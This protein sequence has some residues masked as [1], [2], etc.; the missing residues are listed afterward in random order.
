ML[1]NKKNSALNSITS[2]F[3]T[4]YSVGC[5]FIEVYQ[6]K[7]LFHVAAIPI[8]A[9]FTGNKVKITDKAIELFL[10]G[11]NIFKKSIIKFDKP[12]AEHSYTII[13]DDKNRAYGIGELLYS[14]NKVDTLPENT[15]VIKN[16]IDVG[17][18]LRSENN[19]IKTER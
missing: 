16:I 8:L 4:C 7:L 6:D 9:E 3:E 10:Y 5:P 2:L 17:F 13:L 15:V 19:F 14:S 12:V 1:V 18:Y 11:R